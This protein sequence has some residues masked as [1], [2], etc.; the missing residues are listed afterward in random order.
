MDFSGTTSFWSIFNL[1]VWGILFLILIIQLI[2]SIRVVP[3]KSAYVVE[4]LG[5]Y[6]R[7]LGPGFHALFPFIDKVKY[8]QNL[9]ETTIDVPPQVCFTK[10]NVKVVVDGVMYV[11]VHDAE[12]ASYGVVDYFVAA[13]ELAQTTTRSIVGLLELDRTFK[14][15]NHISS[16]VVEVLS[17]AGQSWGVNVLR[18]EIKNI[19]PPK[20]VQ[21]A[22]EKQVSAERQKRATIAESEGF[23][24][25]RI[26]RSEGV[27][28]EM[29]NQSDGECQRVINEAE[30]KAAGILDVAK[31]TASS[32]EKIGQSL[33]GENGA[34]ALY[35]QLSQKYL[36]NFALMA[37]GENKVVIPADVTDM[38]AMLSQFTNLKMVTE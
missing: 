1:I 2:R 33:A 29:I 35:L 26:N 10:D 30:G 3:N 4:R 27:K 31:A 36:Q 19:S 37:K 16:R 25:S 21:E 32:I 5:R 17:E 8:I 14:E 15:R 6:D 7:T 13:S 9:K 23:M 11:E 34:D 12:K 20:S 24:Q 18:Y 38:K 28:I 22:M